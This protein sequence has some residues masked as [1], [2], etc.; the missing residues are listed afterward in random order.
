[1]KICSVGL[2]TKVVEKIAVRLLQG[3]VRLLQG[4]VGLL[5]HQVSFVQAAFSFLN[6]GKSTVI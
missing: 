3:L 4:L 6:K 1:V 5:Q 2:Y